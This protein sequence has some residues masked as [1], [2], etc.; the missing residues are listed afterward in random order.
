MASN[1]EVS[2]TKEDLDQEVQR[3]VTELGRNVYHAEL[4]NQDIQSLKNKIF[5]LNIKAYKLDNP[6][7]AV[8]A[9]DGEAMDESDEEF[10]ELENE[11]SAAEE[12]SDG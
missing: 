7:P 10:V 8:E 4:L 1:E 3:L 9:E 2:Y 5:E 11:T 12:P 6:E